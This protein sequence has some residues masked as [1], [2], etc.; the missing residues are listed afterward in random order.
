MTITIE[1][2][3]GNK[4]KIRGRENIQTSS[5]TDSIWTWLHKRNLKRKIKSLL[6]ASQYIVYRLKYK[7]NKL[8]KI[9]K[10]RL[11]RNKC[12]IQSHN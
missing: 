8:N 5:F 1:T 7:K 11:Y 9:S 4:L 12:E 3:A 2:V 6:I 10:W